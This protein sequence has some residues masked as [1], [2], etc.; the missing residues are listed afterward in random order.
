MS[1]PEIDASGPHCTHKG[2][3]KVTRVKRETKAGRTQD[4]LHQCVRYTGHD[5]SLQ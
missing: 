3:G 5:E 2:R 4:R 1:F